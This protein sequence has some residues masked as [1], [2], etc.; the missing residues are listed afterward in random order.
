MTTDTTD[1]VWSAVVRSTRARRRAADIRPIVADIQAGGATSLR[2]IA[3]VLNE[4][5]IRAAQGKEWAAT[6]VMRV[7]DRKRPRRDWV[8]AEVYG[9]G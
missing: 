7:L 2:Q 4:R 6:Q 5:H 9:D 8:G 3:A 1:T